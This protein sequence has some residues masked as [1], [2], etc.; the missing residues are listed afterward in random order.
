VLDGDTASPR[1]TAPNFRPMFVMAKRAGW[2]KIRL[3]TDVGLG[4]GHIV[5]DDGSAA[6][7]IG[8]HHPPNT[9]RVYDRRQGLSVTLVYVA[10]RLDGSRCQLKRHTVRSPSHSPAVLGK[11]AWSA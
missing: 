2:I 4:P 11:I 7:T 6:P 8:V 3:G 1:G 5:L 10:K 9:V